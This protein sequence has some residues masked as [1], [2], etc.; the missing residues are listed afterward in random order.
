MKPH[1][2]NLNPENGAVCENY[3]RPIQSVT[4]SLFMQRT[5]SHHDE[6]RNDSMECKGKLFLYE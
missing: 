3:K 2:P 5:P 4:D 1:V 6:Q